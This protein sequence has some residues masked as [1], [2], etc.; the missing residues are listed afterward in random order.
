MDVGLDDEQR[1]VP[2]NNR[3]QSACLLIGAGGTGKTTIILK[4]LLEVFLEFFPTE[5]SGLER[6][7]IA[8]FSHGQGDAISNETFRAKFVH[9]AASYRVASLRTKHLALKSKQQEMTNRWQNKI[10]LIQDEAS[11]IPGMVQNMFLYRTMRARQGVH[12]LDP[13]AYGS[14]NHLFGHLPIVII[15]GDFL[16]I[17]P[18]NEI[19]IADD[20]RALQ[21][22]GKN[23]HPEHTAAQEAILGISDV[24]HLKKSRRFLDDDMPAITT[25][26]RLSTDDN[27][28]AEQMLSKLRAR[29]IDVCQSELRSDLFQQGHVVGIYWE[30]IARAMVERAH[31]D[32]QRLN[33]P[34]LCI[35]AADQ[36]RKLLSKTLDAQLVHALLTVPNLH[37]TGKLPGMLLL[38]EGMLVRFTDVLSP[39][40][41]LVKDKLCRVVSVVLH[42]ADQKRIENL[43]PGYRQFFPHFLPKG[44]W[45]QVLKFNCAPLAT[46]LREHWHA[47]N[48]KIQS[49]QE[50]SLVFVELVHAEFTVEV[51]VGGEKQ[52]V[53]A[54]RYQFPLTHGML[55]TAYA[56]QGLTLEG[57]VLVD[58]RRAGGLSDDDWWLAI[59][60]MLSRARKLENLILFGFNTQVEELLKRGPPQNLRK[61]T[62]DLE[63]KAA[64][65]M[66]SLATW[67]EYDAL[68]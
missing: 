28:I 51:S 44:T 52:E 53:R 63:A 41:G 60:V 33:L 18:A 65:T 42:P 34:P 6:Y 58:L 21:H 9:S 36:R 35:Q 12:L 24:I 54:I 26:M 29:S 46:C 40:L 64:A 19:S 5:Q 62:A 17:K 39:H 25:T 1:H 56:A 48:Y 61:V 22:A 38:H 68:G 7:L 8:T 14:Q 4:L 10:L 67:P 13:V 30:H 3:R 47:H 43:S 49:G 59:Y 2:I 45:V 15:A 20:L 37:R 23:V 66:L 27:P 16:Q 57:G 31:R 50:A 32:A 11:L 55:R